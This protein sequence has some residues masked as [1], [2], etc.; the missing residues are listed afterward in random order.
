[1]ENQ[2][3]S[4]FAQGGEGKVYEIIGKPKLVA[5]L[6]KNNLNTTEKERKL[7]TMVD[8]P[9]DKNVMDQISW[10]VDVLY[11]NRHT[12]VGFV[13]PKLSIN[14]ELNVIYEYGTTAKYKNIPW[15]NK[16][17]V[18][19]NLCVVLDAVHKAGHVVGDL[20]PKNISVDPNTGHVIFVDT[21]SYHIED[22]GTVYRCSVGMPEYLPAE[23]QKKMK[24][25]LSSC[26]LPT[27]SQNSDNFA[28]AVHIFQLLMNG[29][30]PFSCRVLP[31]QASVAFPQPTDNILNGVFPFMQPSA[32]TAIPMYA[33]PIDVLPDDM[34]ALFA[35]AF[36]VGHCDPAQRPSAE[37]W[38]HALC[39]LEKNL[40]TCK[41]CSHHQYFNG[42]TK[43][44]WCEADARFNGGK[45]GKPPIGIP[46]GQSTFSLN[47]NSTPLTPPSK[48]KGAS[49][50]KKVLISFISVFIALLI[51]FGVGG[52]LYY[53]NAL[54]EVEVTSKLIEELPANSTD[55]EMYGEYI[56]SAY[57]SYNNLNNWQKK[58][59]DNKDKLLTIV[60][61]YNEYMVD[62]LLECSSKISV[63]TVKETT[64]LRETVDRYQ[65]L[66]G[67]QKHL[68]TNEDITV[69]D[70]YVKVYQVIY[71]IDE[72]N[73]DLVNKYENIDSVKIIYS[74]IGEKYKELV[75]NYHLIDQFNEKLE[76]LNQF[77]FTATGDG[78]SVKLASNVE[79][80]GHLV[81]PDVYS[82]KS[83]VTIEE[84]AFIDQ[85]KITSIE[86]PATVTTIK[87]GAF[88]GCNNV[89]EIT[90]PF[91]GQTLS[92]N[93][94]LSHIFGG[95]VPQSLKMINVTHQDRIENSM[96]VNCN[97][98]EKVN[99]VNDL[100]YLGANAFSGCESLTTLNN[101]SQESINITGDLD[102]IGDS[103]FK[104]CSS[105]RKIIFSREILTIGNNAFNGCRN[106]E[107]LKL[108]DR[109]TKIGDFSFQGLRKIKEVIVPNSVQYVG[110]GAF[111]ECSALEK[112]QVPF[113]GVSKTSSDYKAVFGAIFGY[114]SAG[115]TDIMWS[116]GFKNKIYSNSPYSGGSAVLS[117]G[118]IWQFSYAHGNIHRTSY[119]YYI[120][121][122]LCEVVV[123]N[124]SNVPIAAFNGCT[125]LNKIV[126]MQGIDSQG[127][128]AFQNC[129]ATIQTTLS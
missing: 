61:A 33:P 55:F 82:R 17:I 124:S 10:P 11:D 40:I 127:D 125:M 81:I 58:K 72:I 18:A 107:E 13:M 28:L 48:S 122:T 109:I 32:G 101:D 99:F 57:V 102:S 42:I 25:G 114:E 91:V 64:H 118:A 19:K 121:S 105:I 103:A 43:C 67:E 98:I 2:N 45:A 53:S 24:G 76:Y 117:N 7:I 120:P 115:Y 23:I 96:F 88:K 60:P 9:P 30:H 128:Y 62:K 44:P 126:F 36:I 104:N 26:S 69:L 22:N 75:Y 73:I 86:V 21:D 56:E 79:F 31:S 59:V 65:A 77:V 15:I 95:E 51:G 66:T 20:N 97:Y 52:G 39:E 35:R 41:K 113:V 47:S 106:V 111:K 37:E 46:G 16:I 87:S 112:I 3:S 1:M 38:H 119:W 83:V 100:E 5:K 71:D 27:F 84:N 90:V 123:T 93:T 108:T 92:S 12:F 70:N 116:S 80:E 89:L 50:K 34:K 63:E 110:V 6:Y 85:R 78:Y 4:P 94:T 29:C 54:K 14:E 74:S 68:L 129:S 49:T 8:N